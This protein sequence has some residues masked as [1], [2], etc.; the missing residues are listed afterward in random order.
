MPTTLSF[1]IQESDSSVDYKIVV[2]DGDFDK[3]GFAEIKDTITEI[4]KEF[5]LKFLIFDFTNL[6]YINSEG[7][8]FLMEVHTHLVQRGRK[9]VIFGLNDHVKDVFQA[10]GIAEIVSIFGSLNDFINST[11]K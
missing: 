9:L 1:Q 10:I 6:E 8:G 7:I 11:E 5:N 2:F 4:V 3:A